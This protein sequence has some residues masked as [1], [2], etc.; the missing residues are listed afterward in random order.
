MKKLLER[1]AFHRLAELDLRIAGLLEHRLRR[2]H[3]AAEHY[4]EAYLWAPR[5]H[6]SSGVRTRGFCWR[7]PMPSTKSSDAWPLAW[8]R[9]PAPGAPTCAPC[10][11]IFWLPMKGYEAEAEAYYPSRARRRSGGLGRA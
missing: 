11:A 3:E 7:E 5:E 6:A 1:E 4:L 10:S 2:P 9:S 8:R